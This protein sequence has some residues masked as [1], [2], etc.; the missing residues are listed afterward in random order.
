M[1]FRKAKRIKQLERENRKLRLK[2][3][4]EEYRYNELK[5][6]SPNVVK[7]ASKTVYPS[8]VPD[9]VVKKETMYMLME[10]LSKDVDFEIESNP[11]SKITTA[12]IE[13]VRRS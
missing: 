3:I 6:E 8:H 4:Y 7:V 13:I 10:E 11:I 1:F 12:S 9:G 5:L 2:L